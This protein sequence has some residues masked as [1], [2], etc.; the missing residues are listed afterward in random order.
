M[1]LSRTDGDH[2]VAGTLSCNELRI[3][4]GTIVDADV[5]GAA[6]IAATKLVHQHALTY[7][8]DDGTDVATATVPIYTVYGSTAEIV[9][10]EV[11]CQDAPAGGAKQ[12]TVDLQSASQTATTLASVLSA[13]VTV[14][15]T[16]AD[17]EVCSGTI[18]DADLEDGETLAIVV[19]ASG[20]TGTQGQGLIATCTLREAAS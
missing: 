15:T 13:A 12:F 10:F 20:T 17:Y 19:T 6:G 3:P 8:Q 14:D 16:V 18:S 7:R 9:A 5:G 1:G 11:V 2:H 4:A